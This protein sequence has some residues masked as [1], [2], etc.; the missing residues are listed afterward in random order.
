MDNFELEP[1]MVAVIDG[2]NEELAVVQ[3][4]RDWLKKEYDRLY[5]E[6]LRNCHRN[7]MTSIFIP[8]CFTE[9]DCNLFYDPTA[10]RN[11]S[12]ED[13]E[14]I[15]EMYN[16][17][18]MDYVGEEKKKAREMRDIFYTEFLHMKKNNLA[19]EDILY[20]SMTS[21]WEIC[22]EN[23]LRDCY[24]DFTEAEEFGE[25]S[26]EDNINDILEFLGGDC[27]WLIFPLEDWDDWY[28]INEN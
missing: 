4:E 28:L 24:V 12:A 20:R 1:S 27:E 21:N 16:Q 3:K 17:Y 15:I 6:K 25:T 22:N 19:C 13:I 2:M 23:Y 18:E 9:M 11:A 14:Y 26:K 8:K 5:K 10:W 7:H